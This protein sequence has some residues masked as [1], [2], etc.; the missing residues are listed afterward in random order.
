MLRSNSSASRPL[1]KS[2]SWLRV[3]EILGRSKSACSTPNSPL[4]RGVATPLAVAGLERPVAEADA[5]ALGRL[6]PRRQ[7][8]GPAQ[9]GGDPRNQLARAEGLRDIVVRA[10][11][12]P[13]DA[14]AFPPAA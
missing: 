10:H 7:G 3:S 9:H 6:L 2:S 1:V 11:L 5:P 13:D 12:Q 8:Q 14:V 4:E